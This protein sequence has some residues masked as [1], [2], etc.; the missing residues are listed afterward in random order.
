MGFINVL[1]PN[2]LTPPK[3]RILK[4]FFDS[5]LTFFYYFAFLTTLFSLHSS[6]FRLFYTALKIKKTSTKNIHINF[7]LMTKSLNSEQAVGKMC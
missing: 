2:K 1:R 7:T 6:L 5:Y 4:P 3:N